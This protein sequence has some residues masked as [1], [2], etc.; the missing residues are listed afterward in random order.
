MTSYLQK[1]INIV[2][3]QLSIHDTINVGDPDLW[4]TSVELMH[5]LLTQL[6][7]VSLAGLVLRTRSKRAKALVCE[8]L[9]YSVP[10]SFPKTQP[11]F[12]GQQF[13]VYTQKSDNL[14]IG[15]QDI[16]P[17]RRYVLLLLNQDDII[18][19]VRVLT[20]I[21]LAVYD[22]TGTLTQ[23][24][25]A[26]LT[27]GDNDTEL[28]SSTDTSN[29]TSLISYQP[30][31]R[32][33]NAS[34]ISPPDPYQLLPIQILFDKLAI[35]V[36]ASVAYVD[37]TQERNRGAGLHK[38][39]CKALGYAT[40]RDNGQFP[41]VRHQLLEV[42]LQTA[43]TIDL[44]LVCPDSETV[45]DI[46]QIEGRQ[47]RHCDIQYG[48]FFG[49]VIDGQV[50]LT[51]F[52]LT[53]GEDFFSRFPKFG[54][55]T[56]NRKIQLRLPNRFL[57]HLLSRYKGNFLFQMVNGRYAKSFGNQHVYLLLQNDNVQC[58]LT[59]VKLT[60]YFYYLISQFSIRVR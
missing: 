24:Y 9:G 54:G 18:C 53:T 27:I 30:A 4:F 44:G 35:L 43:S 25:Q 57:R 6:L 17:E 28:I 40:F 34:P 36:G 32:L 14:Q 52:Y 37:F 15:N 7:G 1:R 12:L 20:G 45:L 3:K 23:K 5:L 49:N 58:I 48:I 55:K 50:V 38:M 60:D 16:D 47:I 11:R 56:I 8:T 39:V 10:N 46:E 41:D 59:G 51:N 31:I 22:T 26:R 29:L 42:K 2:R 19:S 21:E 13:D 33:L